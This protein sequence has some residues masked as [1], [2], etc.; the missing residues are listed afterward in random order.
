MHKIIVP[1]LLSTLILVRPFTLFRSL[2]EYFRRGGSRNFR[3]GGPVKGRSP[4]PSA[5]RS[6]GLPQKILKNHMRFMQSGICFC[7][8]NGVGCHSKLGLCRT[9]NSSGYDFE[10]HGY[11]IRKRLICRVGLWD[12]TD[13]H[14][15]AFALH[16]QKLLGFR[17]L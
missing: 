17:P 2:R 7:D 10:T 8:Q 9:K 3:K 13:T 15:H 5:G 4:E 1:L 6:V 16:F 12:H 11:Y 14:T